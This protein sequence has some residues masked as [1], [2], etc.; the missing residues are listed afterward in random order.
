LDNEE[1]NL[2]KYL[3]VY[4]NEYIANSEKNIL[5][6]YH[7]EESIVQKIDKNIFNIIIDNLVSNAVKFSHENGQIEIG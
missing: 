7:F 4:I 2:E 6:S 1:V 3:P 5:L